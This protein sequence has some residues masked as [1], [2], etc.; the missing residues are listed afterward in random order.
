MLSCGKT[1]VFGIRGYVYKK[2]AELPGDVGAHRQA[3]AYLFPYNPA[4]RQAVDLS[5]GDLLRAAGR[6][7]CWNVID[8][9]SLAVNFI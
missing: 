2:R 6:I 9:Y 5:S 1:K 7:S 3:K 8:R 4:Y